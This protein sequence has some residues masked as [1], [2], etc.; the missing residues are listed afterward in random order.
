[1]DIQEQAVMLQIRENV[2][3]ICAQYGLYGNV[4][5]REASLIPYSDKNRLYIIAGTDPAISNDP[6]P[7]QYAPDVIIRRREQNEKLF[8][9]DVWAYDLTTHSDQLKAMEELVEF[10]RHSEFL[11]TIYGEHDLP[12]PEKIRESEMRQIRVYRDASKNYDLTVPVMEKAKKDLD[13]FFKR[14][15]SAGLRRRWLDFFRSDKFPDDKGPIA[16][17]KAYS[18]YR[19]KD[20]RVSMEQ[21]MEFN[22]DIKKLEMQEHEYILWADYLAKH[23]PEVTYVE[24]AKDIVNHGVDKPGQE[25]LAPFGRRIT[26]EEFAVIRKERFAEEGWDCLADVKPSYWEFRDVYYK[27]ADAA[28]VSEAYHAVTLQ[29]A[30]PNSL[31]E[32]MCSGPIEM[33]DIS[34]SDLMNFV[35]LSKANGLRFYFDIHDEFDT[36]SL[37]KIH[38][39]YN[40]SQRDLLEGVADRMISDKVTYSH[41]I[42]EA[43]RPAL[44]DIIFHAEQLQGPTNPKEIGDKELEI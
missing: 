23:Y 8:Y 21:M 20:P 4:Y 42:D 2:Q 29:Y 31:G 36:P 16:K 30:K 34:T 22:S 28:L 18:R 7:D 11:S 43:D 27:E 5:F 39:I 1:M 17:L 33:A 9:P 37:D 15:R 24:G 32:L 19:R 44:Q 38:V 40:S 10:C 26:G 35:S 14:E 6:P 41:L 12:L 13:W 3:H 25:P